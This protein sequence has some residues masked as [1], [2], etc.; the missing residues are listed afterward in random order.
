MLR[1]YGASDDLV[2]IEGIVSDEL[3][4][5]ERARTITVGDTSGGVV[6]RVEYAVANRAGVWSVAFEPIDEDV[7][8]P[9]PISVKLNAIRDGRGYSTEASIDCPAG[10]PVS[11]AE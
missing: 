9:W 4:A 1:I 11:W 10:T 7:P 8:I 5:Y 3:G 2:E 6:V